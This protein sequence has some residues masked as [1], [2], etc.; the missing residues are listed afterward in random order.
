MGMWGFM[1]ERPAAWRS[2]HIAVSFADGAGM[3]WDRSALRFLWWQRS[4]KICSLSNKVN[5][6]KKR[7]E[8][9]WKK[10]PKMIITAEK[11]CIGW[12]MGKR[13]FLQM[14]TLIFHLFRYLCFLLDGLVS[15]SLMYDVL[16]YMLYWLLPT[17]WQRELWL[18]GFNI[19]SFLA[20]EDDNT[21]QHFI[22]RTG[23][24]FADIC[25]ISHYISIH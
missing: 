8:G 11:L 17:L 7:T 14:L 20:P 24:L 1:L 19:H 2:V 22:W 10:R 5:G 3:Q 6:Q 23:A 25:Y 15:R 13:Q 4:T 21:T 9:L 12:I 18:C 16:I